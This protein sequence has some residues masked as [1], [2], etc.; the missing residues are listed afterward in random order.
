MADHDVDA[1]VAAAMGRGTD[2]EIYDQAHEKLGHVDRADDGLAEEIAPTDV[3]KR[4]QH[5]HPEHDRP[6]ADEPV[7]GPSGEGV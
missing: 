2:A 6:H 4:H 1:D 3:E 7:S 5:H